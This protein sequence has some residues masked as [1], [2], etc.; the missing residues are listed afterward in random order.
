MPSLLHL[1]NDVHLLILSYLHHDCRALA[2]TCRTFHRLCDLPSRRRFRRVRVQ[3]GKALDR[4]FDLLLAILRRPGLG[5]YVRHLEYQGTVEA[6]VP[7][8]EQPGDREAGLRDE[9]GTM[10]L[11]RAAVQRAIGVDENDADEQRTKLAAQVMNMLMQSSEQ[12][13]KGGW[14]YTCRGMHG[15]FAVQ[16][17]AALL[18]SVAPDL[19]SMALVQPF[20]NYTGFYHTEGRFANQNRVAFPLD[21]ILRRANGEEDAAPFLRQLRRVYFI[22]VGHGWMDDER[23]YTSMDFLGMFALVDRLPSIETVST[24]VL[25]EDENGKPGLAV[26]SSNISR[27]RINHSAVDTMYLASVIFFRGGRASSDGSSPMQNP[28]TFLQTLLLHRETLEV[29]DVDFEANISEFWNDD[30]ED[31]EP[32]FDTYGGRSDAHHSWT[33]APPDELWEQKG[34]LQDFTS[35]THVSLGLKTLLYMARG[36]DS[37]RPSDFKLVDQ[38]PPNLEYLLIRGYERGLRKDHDEHIDGLLS[39]KESESSKLREI[40]G[41]DELIPHAEDV[42]EP[43]DESAALW[44]WEEEEWSEDE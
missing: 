38:L 32:D 11:L 15:I 28:K 26:N 1:P 30:D 44:E 13:N 3:P 18:V 27:I 24:D 21:Y 36:V 5:R 25:S 23:F 8:E 17:V 6:H 41:V 12:R 10:E 9:P 20:F 43:D 4:A 33:G 29:L 39:L 7:Y 2:L 37:A 22:N 34:S 16:A 19:E 42:D 35:L 14:N 40:R 31:T